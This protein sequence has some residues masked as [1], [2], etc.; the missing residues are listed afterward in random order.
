MNFLLETIRLGLKNL[1]LH[2]LRSA[3]TSL[4]II[5]GVAAVIV[6][7]SIGEGNKRAA[8]RGIEALGATNIIVRSSNP[9]ETGSMS[10]EE[11]SW[12]AKYGLTRNEFERLEFN[13]PDV[14]SV[15]PLKAVGGEISY[16]AHRLPSQ[17]FG[18]TPELRD[19][20][21]LRVGSRGRYINHEDLRRRAAVAVIGSEIAQKFFRLRD[22]LGATFR[23]DDQLFRV[24]GVLEPVGLAGGAGSALVGRDLNNDVHIP[25]P[26]AV[27]QFGDTVIRRQTG[28]FSGEEVELSEIYITAS[29]TDTVLNT[30]DRVRRLVA[31]DHPEFKD[32][33]II[34]PWELLEEAKR[35]ALVWNVVLISIAAISLLVGGI[36]IMNIML[37]SVT[38]RTREIGIRRALGATRKHII[39][40]FLVETGSL[41]GAG[42]ILGILFGLVVSVGIGQLLPWL[43]NLPGLQGRFENINVVETQI[44]A[45]SIV[46]S[47]LVAAMVGLIF[48]IY[49]AV[50]ASRQDPIV[51][52]RHD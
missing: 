45:W 12:I 17:V 32:V 11:R 22:P 20:A 28:S 7:V 33:Q 29:S 43:L 1:R 14:A 46:V 8:L 48:G 23:V 9:P 25:L 4:G 16:R 36:G 34:V 24:I 50:V 44:T 39:A 13:L 18:V 10:G 49:P 41:T 42:G 40:Q 30:A 31:I 47:F 51:A 3:L 26:T 52:L 37:A 35:T 19:V 21:N 27:G 5:L 2:L 38:E 15:V 6:M